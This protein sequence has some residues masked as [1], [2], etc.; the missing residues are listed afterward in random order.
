MKR[1]LT[2]AILLAL[3][4]TTAHAASINLRHEHNFEHGQHDTEQKQRIAVSHRFA[5]GIGFEVES[6]FKQGEDDRLASDSNGQQTNISYR[7][8]LGESFTLT[9]QYKVEGSGDLAHQFNL[10]LGYKINDEWSVSYRQRYNQSQHDNY[11][12]QGTF[13]FSYKGIEDWGISGSTDYRVAGGDNGGKGKKE[14][15]DG[16]NKG[17]NEINFKAQYNGL[18]SGWKPFTEFGV[19]PSAKE[20][21]DNKDSWRP[22]IRVGVVYNF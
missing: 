2:S 7:M 21:G 15:W 20:K 16:D 18:E 14:I 19:T 4:A 17:I 9:P 11:Y 1:V 5:N 10:T 3:T 22:R 6:K 13:A 8:K 12:N